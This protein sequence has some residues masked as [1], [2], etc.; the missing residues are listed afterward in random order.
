MFSDYNR[1]N[2]L[3][4]VFVHVHKDK[5]LLLIQLRRIYPRYC[6][7]SNTQ[8]PDALCTAKNFDRQR[9]EDVEEEVMQIFRS[10]KYVEK[11]ARLC[12]PDSTKRLLFV[13]TVKTYNDYHQYAV[14][15]ASNC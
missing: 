5:K 9:T 7:Q 10:Q 13:S 15:I 4:N 3:L 14:D 1:Q 6:I 12:F 2:A 8:S 11:R